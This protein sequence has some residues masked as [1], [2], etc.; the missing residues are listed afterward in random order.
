MVRYVL[1]YRNTVKVWVTLK[2][3]PIQACIKTIKLCYI[4]VATLLIGSLARHVTESLFSENSLCT[5]INDI[6][7]T[8]EAV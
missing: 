5:H 4:L 3:L 2:A 1:E 7:N 8:E 6:R